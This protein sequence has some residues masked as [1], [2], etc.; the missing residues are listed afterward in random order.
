[1][2]VEEYLHTSFENPDPEFRDGE[3]VARNSCDSAYSE[4]CVKL[5]YFFMRDCQSLLLHCRPGR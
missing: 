1:M 4:T 2:T 5:I 3:L